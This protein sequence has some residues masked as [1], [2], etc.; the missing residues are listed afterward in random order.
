MN[1]VEEVDLDDAVRMQ[2]SPYSGNQY[3]GGGGGERDYGHGGY[4]GA[5]YDNEVKC[6]Q[7]LV[8]LPSRKNQ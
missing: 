6:V 2:G 5:N 4:S 3:S 1:R 8:L 7:F